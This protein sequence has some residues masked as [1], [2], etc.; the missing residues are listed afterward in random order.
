MMMRWLSEFLLRF[1][2]EQA[3]MEAGDKC[4]GLDC[5]NKQDE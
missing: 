1:L 5:T 2:L 3:N 4:R